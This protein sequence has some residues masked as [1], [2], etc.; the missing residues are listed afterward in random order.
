MY[1]TY[2]FQNSSTFFHHLWCLHDNRYGKEIRLY[3]S[4][5]K[6]RIFR[7][8]AW[9]SKDKSFHME[10]RSFPRG[11]KK[12]T[13]SICHCFTSQ[14]LRMKSQT[15]EINGS[16]AIDF[17]GPKMS[18]SV[19]YYTQKPDIRISTVLWSTVQHNSIHQSEADHIITQ[20]LFPLAS[21]VRF[22]LVFFSLYHHIGGGAG[23][24]LSHV[25]QQYSFIPCQYYVV[26]VKVQI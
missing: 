4:W 7:V 2:H 25:C 16:F 6:I 19:L 24:K 22:I 8:R 9:K 14:P 15:A 18:S 11:K 21:M 1:T 23:K 20:S 5:I 10:Q 17:N 12:Y 26:M 13:K 3:L